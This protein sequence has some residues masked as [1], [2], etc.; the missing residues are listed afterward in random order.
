MI[1]INNSQMNIPYNELKN[2][3]ETILIKYGFE[4]QKAG[5]CA[6]IF[7]GNSR[8]GVYSHGLNRFP[9]FIQHIKEGYINIHA[10]PETVNRED[11]I[12]HWDGHL[13]PG[14]YT[15]TLAMQRAIVNAKENSMG[16]VTVKNS[17]HW[18]RGGTY[19]W[20]AADAGCIGICITNTLANMPPWGGLNPRLG[21]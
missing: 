10:E 20:Q 5:I 6:N 11:V 19:G 21:N 18:M 4:K 15:A 16:C 17:N 14:I 13:A 2:Q 9:T 8:D 12:E 1:I 3:F 7:A